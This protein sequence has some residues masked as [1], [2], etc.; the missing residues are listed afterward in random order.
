[1]LGCL[2]SLSRWGVN[3]VF[4]LV[5]C[6][7][8]VLAV[9]EVRRQRGLA[10]FAGKLFITELIMCFAT[11]FATLEIER[12]F[13][14]RQPW[15]IVRYARRLR[16]SGGLV[17]PA[18]SEWGGA[19]WMPPD[20]RKN[21]KHG[22]LRFFLL[23]IPFPAGNGMSPPLAHQWRLCD[24]REQSPLICLRKGGST[25]QGGGILISPYSDTLVR[26]S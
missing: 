18:V 26:L 12:G 16:G 5:F 23:L 24:Q 3:K 6:R 19:A 7:L 9:Y 21:R 17:R 22:R 8:S 13:Y 20:N 14:L 15:G 11:C 10:V 1:L 2:S 25:R 4:I